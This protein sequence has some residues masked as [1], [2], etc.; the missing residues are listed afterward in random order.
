MCVRPKP[1]FARHLLPA[2]AEATPGAGE[3][4][5]NQRCA[6]KIALNLKFQ[7]AIFAEG[8][9]KLRALDADSGNAPVDLWRGLRNLR[10]QNAFIKHGGTEQA[11]MKKPVCTRPCACKVYMTNSLALS[12]ASIVHLR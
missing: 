3:Q 9:R 8:I 5:F 4:K 12:L 11:P 2:F 10:V 6:D 7:S 1:R